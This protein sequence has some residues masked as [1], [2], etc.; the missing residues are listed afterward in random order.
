MVQAEE[1]S[2]A[3]SMELSH[4]THIAEPMGVQNSLKLFAVPALKTATGQMALQVSTAF[5]QECQGGDQR[6]GTFASHEQPGKADFQ[7][8][9]PCPE[10][11]SRQLSSV[12]GSGQRPPRW[13]LAKEFAACPWIDHRQIGGEAS[14]FQ[15]FADAVARGDKLVMLALGKP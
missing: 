6:V 15:G 1:P 8:L 2:Q 4:Q 9:G 10:L 12:K 7:R 11:A 13:F 5:P 3:V 14:V